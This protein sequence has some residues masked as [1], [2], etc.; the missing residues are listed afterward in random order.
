MSICFR[1]GPW[2]GQ[3]RQGACCGWWRK[4]LCSPGVRKKLYWRDSSVITALWM[5]RAKVRTQYTSH[6]PAHAITYENR[7]WKSHA[8][9]CGQCIPQAPPCC[10]RVRKHIASCWVTAMGLTGWSMML[11]A[12]WAMPNRIL[13]LRMRPFYCRTL[14][15]KTLISACWYKHLVNSVSVS[16]VSLGCL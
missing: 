7:I 14:I 3:M 6:M 10:W 9:S 11:A 2:P 1:Y 12:G 16:A 4:K 15:S 13:P 5:E 8:T